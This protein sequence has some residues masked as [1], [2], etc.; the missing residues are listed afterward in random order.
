MTGM[1][2]NLGE[3]LVDISRNWIEATKTDIPQFKWDIPQI[4]LGIADSMKEIVSAPILEAVKSLAD[5]ADIAKETMLMLIQEMAKKGWTLTDAVAFAH[6]S[7]PEI[8]DM[9][10][11][12]LDSY[13]VE[14]YNSYLYEEVKNYTCN[15]VEKTQKPLLK[16]VYK[17]V[18]SEMYL[19]AIP[20][21]ILII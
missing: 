4:E 18:D 13:F 14:I 9:S 20:S 8:L 5:S 12:T 21:L 11:E 6:V 7:D 2:K 19:V 1:G 3:L 17:A 15:Y 10:R 16:E